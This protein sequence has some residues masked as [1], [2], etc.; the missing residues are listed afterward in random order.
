M[1]RAPV[2]RGAALRLPVRRPP[3]LRPRLHR[4]RQHV[5][6]PDAR[7]IHARARRLLCAAHTAHAPEGRPHLRRPH[8]RDRTATLH[9]CDSLPR[10]K[11][12]ACSAGAHSCTRR[13]LC[14]SRRSPPLS[15][16]TK[17]RPLTPP[18]VPRTL[19]VPHL[20]PAATFSSVSLCRPAS[21]V[22]R[23]KLVPSARMTDCVRWWCAV[24]AC[25]PRRRG[26]DRAGDAALARAGRTPHQP[27]RI[28]RPHPGSSTEERSTAH[29]SLGYLLPVP[30]PPSFM[31]APRERLPVPPPPPRGGASY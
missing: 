14:A 8:C 25:P 26:A 7:A 22:V 31:R 28:W 13:L 10:P 23:L 29:C 18:H 4:G 9:G 16:A 17:R 6:R 2:H 5:L 15:P 24:C 11:N 27:S 20:P 19:Y 3:L 30:R 1:R 12:R 21:R